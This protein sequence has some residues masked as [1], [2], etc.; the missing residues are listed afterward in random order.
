MDGSRV[1][2]VPSKYLLNRLDKHKLK[3][4]TD[5]FVTI[6]FFRN[7]KIPGSFVTPQPWRR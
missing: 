4:A 1:F 7:L 2:F 3:M 6:F 5:S